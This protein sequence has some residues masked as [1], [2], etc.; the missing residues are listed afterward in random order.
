MVFV[1]KLV[2]VSTPTE[3]IIA[4]VTLTTLMKRILI[5]LQLLMKSCVQCKT[6]ITAVTYQCQKYQTNVYFVPSTATEKES[7]EFT[8]ER[9]VC[10]CYLLCPIFPKSQKTV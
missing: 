2:N 4:S 1:A 3:V 8:T 5:S 7:Y 10:A 9:G 6:F